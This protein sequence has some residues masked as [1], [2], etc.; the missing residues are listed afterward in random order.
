MGAGF[1]NTKP[2]IALI[3]NDQG[4]VLAQGLSIYLNQKTN[5]ISIP[6][7]EESLQDALFFRQVEYIVKVPAGFSQSFING[8]YD[9]RI[10]KT[11]VHNSESSVYMDFLIN[12]Y[13]ST[14][15]LYTQSIPGISGPELNDLVKNDLDKQT[16]VK[17][18]ENKLAKYYTFAVYGV[19]NETDLKRRNLASPL[20]SFNMN[21]QLFLG[22]LSFAAVVWIIM[23]VLG[24][25]ISGQ[26]GF[27]LNSVMMYI[28][29][30]C[31]TFVCMSLRFL[32]GNLISSRYAQQAVANVLSLGLCFISGV[33]VPQQLLA[34]P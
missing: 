1:S 31:F 13:L 22:N 23:I 26:V 17:T 5:V 12:R 30:L 9:V 14:A 25:I 32:I 34:N 24:F 33:F 16:S 28:N 19:F 4:A 29:L 27:N 6:N 2:N 10:E 7:N 18:M 3:D 15:R 21:M 20:K 8:R 11:R